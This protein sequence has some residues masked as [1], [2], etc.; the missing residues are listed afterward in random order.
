VLHVEATTEASVLTVARMTTGGE[1]ALIL[2]EPDVIRM[3]SM[4]VKVAADSQQ[5]DGKSS[6]I[7]QLLQVVTGRLVDIWKLESTV[8][9]FSVL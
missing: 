9:Q 6:R 7:E 8:V 2:Q 5:K 3:V 1:I 4:Q